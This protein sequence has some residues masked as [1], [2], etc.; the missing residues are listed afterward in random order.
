MPAPLPYPQHTV[1]HTP[2]EDAQGITIG[3]ITTAIALTFLNS[4]GFITGQTAGVALIVSYLTGVSFSW[5]FF[6]INIPFYIFAWFRMGP[7]FTLKSAFC[8]TALSVMMGYIPA[9]MPFDGLNPWFGTIAFGVLCGFG[10][11]G[12]F[13]HKASLGGLGVVALMI[14]D[15]TGFRAGYVQII[16]DVIIFGTAAALL[17]L[18]VV[19][20]SLLGAL[21]LNTVIAFNHRRDRYIAN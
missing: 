17:P 1:P 6:L 21:V 11:L 19:L 12:I 9:L 7:E 18:R 16:F 3:L 20:F 14:Q 10:L 15:R 4:L 13:R 8:V 2:V 5:V